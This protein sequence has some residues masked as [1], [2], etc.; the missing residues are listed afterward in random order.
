MGAA[1]IVP[2]VSGGTIALVF[3]IYDALI[4]TLSTGAGA[5]GRLLRGDLAGTG[6]ALRRIDWR[7]LVALLV[8]MGSAILLLSR[9]I[10]GLLEDQPVVMSALFAGLVAGSVVLAM[11]ELHATPSGTHVAV[12]AL[13]GVTTFVALGVTPSRIVDPSL[14][15][16][17]GAAAVAIC[18]MILPGISGSFILLLLGMYEPVLAAISG[19]DLGVLAVFAAGAVTGLALF[20]SWLDRLLLR[21]HDL[22]LAVLIGLMAGSM[23][24]LWPWP[25]GPEGV[26]D[27][28][29]G[30]PVSGDVVPAL[31]ATLVGLV[32]VVAVARIG[33]LTVGDDPLDIDPVDPPTD[34]PGRTTDIDAG[35]T[36]R[37]DEVGP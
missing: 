3:G 25:A 35:R 29:L 32:V 19:R 18:A 12:M 15:M 13:V 11:R 27:A 1:E 24:V 31:V 14:P 36:A 7:F 6:D 37:S 20:S 9:V 33:D 4:T 2:G 28:R 22:T 23:R 17:F 8:G 10:E 30:A 16:F 26:G 5:L 21:R 34:D